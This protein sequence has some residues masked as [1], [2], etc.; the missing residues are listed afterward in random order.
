MQH[1]RDSF[2]VA[3]QARCRKAGTSSNVRE[4]APILYAAARRNR[5]A[6]AILAAVA[7]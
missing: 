5:N 2:F 7:R 6:S 3:K 1:S 4:I